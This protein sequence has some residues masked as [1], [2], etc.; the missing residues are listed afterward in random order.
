MGQTYQKLFGVPFTSLRLFN[1]YGPRLR[2]DLAL[3]IFTRKILAGERLPLYGD[4]SILR[5][6]THVNDICAGIMAAFTA[7]NIA[8]ECIN[9]GHNEPI[10]VRRLIALIE[11]YSGKKAAIEFLPPRAGDM[12]VTCADLTKSCRLL[13]YQPQVSIE[14]GVKEYVDWMRS[15][16]GHL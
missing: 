14:Q 7:P 3:C 2:P 8:V 1:V 5:D 11:Q 16:Q 9:L 15:A 12:P 13:G 6:F 4:G 10:E